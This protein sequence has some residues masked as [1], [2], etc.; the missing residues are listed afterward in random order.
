MKTV[1]LYA[2]AVALNVMEMQLI[3]VLYA[4]AIYFRFLMEPVDVKLV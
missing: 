1:A 4:P 2:I 3:S